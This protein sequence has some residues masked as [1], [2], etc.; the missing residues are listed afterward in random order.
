MSRIIVFV[1]WALALAGL[2]RDGVASA[3]SGHV[4]IMSLGDLWQTIHADSLIAVHDFLGH[5]FG[6]AIV[7]GILDWPIWGLPLVLSF[8]VIVVRSI[9]RTFYPK[10]KLS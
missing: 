5:G 3:Q 7:A 6:G 10:V 8:F 4:E 9:F 2:G 1:L